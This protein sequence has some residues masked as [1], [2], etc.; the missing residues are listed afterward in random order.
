MV[1]LALPKLLEKGFISYV[2]KGGIKEY[3]ATSPNNVLKFIEEKKNQFREIL[4]ELLAKQKK[5]ISPEAEVYQGFKGIK[6]MLY[7]HIKNLKKGDESLFFTFYVENPETQI[8]I[9]NFLG[10]EYQK[11]REAK[12]LAV[13]GLAPIKLKEL[14]KRYKNKRQIKY[15]D[16][17]IPLNMGI[18]KDN[19]AFIT[20]EES[21]NGFIIHSKQLAN[22]FRDY[23]YSIWNNQ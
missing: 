20:S 6:T 14:Y 10:G 19:V 2:K 3:S 17:P 12:G 22:S 5:E 4:P 7:D 11:E 13:K 15:V 1:H 21:L 9:Y 8:E 23:F 16:F 18:T